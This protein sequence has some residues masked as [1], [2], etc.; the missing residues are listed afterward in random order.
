MTT[1]LV[2]CVS[3]YLTGSE[4]SG[5]WG[6]FTFDGGVGYLGGQKISKVVTRGTKRYLLI[7]V[8]V[9]HLCDVLIQ[10]AGRLGIEVVVLP[11]RKLLDGTEGWD[12]L[13]FEE[14]T[15]HIRAA[16]HADSDAHFRYRVVLANRTRHHARIYATV[17]GLDWDSVAHRF[18][19][20][21]VLKDDLDLLTQFALRDMGVENV[22]GD[23][24]FEREQQ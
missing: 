2:D 15:W 12:E 4:K 3:N 6:E 14:Y 18:T 13:F 22:Y 8:R 23:K 1:K 17:L 11:D 10:I 24:E 7:N 20:D 9:H 16:A 5:A 21:Y 19:P